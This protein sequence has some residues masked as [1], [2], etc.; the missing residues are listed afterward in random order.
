MGGSPLNHRQESPFQKLF[1][2]YGPWSRGNAKA[3]INQ[4]MNVSLDKIA[5]LPFGLVV[6]QWRWDV[7]AGKV[8]PAD[9]NGRWWQLRTKYQGIVPPIERTAADFDPGAKYHVPAN[10]PY[11]RYFL[12]TLLQFQ[13]HRALCKKAGQTGPL[14]TCSIHG[15]KEAGEALRAMLALGASRP[16]PE[17]LEAM[18][19][20]KQMDAGAMLEYFAPLNAWLE[21]QNKGQTCGW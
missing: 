15:S 21:V 12:S 9:Y 19:G 20:E 16:W 11:T 8:Q 6:D 13:F 1:G 3:V 5:F 17:A 4:Q 14:N 2:P 7:F 10:V 18:T